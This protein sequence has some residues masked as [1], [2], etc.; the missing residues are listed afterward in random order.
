MIT[1]ENQTKDTKKNGGVELEKSPARHGDVTG[2][3]RWMRGNT[4]WQINKTGLF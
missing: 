2:G 3:A 4:M 1:S